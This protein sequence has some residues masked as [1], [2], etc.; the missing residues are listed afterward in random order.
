MGSYPCGVVPVNV[1]PKAPDLFLLAPVTIA[2]GDPLARV[3]G[4]SSG[5]RPLFPGLRL[6]YRPPPLRLPPLRCPAALGQ[7]RIGGEDQ[8][9]RP[10]AAETD[11]LLR[12]ERLAE[13]EHRQQELDARGEVLQ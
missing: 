2:P 9:R 3:W 1:R 5:P 11:L 8:Q 4:W 6:G 13:E 12:P 7:Q 10:G